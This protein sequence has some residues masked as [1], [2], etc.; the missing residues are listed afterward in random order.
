MGCLGVELVHFQGL[1][2][3]AS[4]TLFFH[5]Q[6]GEVDSFRSFHFEAEP[7][8]NCFLINSGSQSQCKVHGNPVPQSLEAYFEFTRVPISRPRGVFLR[9]FSHVQSQKIF[10]IKTKRT[11]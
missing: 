3:E 2:L 7:S 10:Y 8:T 4:G 9:K 11:Y 1:P 5:L 6:Y